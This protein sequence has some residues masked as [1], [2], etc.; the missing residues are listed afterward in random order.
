[1][2]QMNL[3]YE[4][5]L[6][7]EQNPTGGRPLTET[8]MEG[9]MDVVTRLMYQILTPLRTPL[10]TPFLLHPKNPLGLLKTQKTQ[11]KQKPEKRLFPFLLHY[12]RKCIHYS[13]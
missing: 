11:V 1:M 5:L 3:D 7:F 9:K 4:V 10:R 2:R 13:R 6:N 12:S 8:V